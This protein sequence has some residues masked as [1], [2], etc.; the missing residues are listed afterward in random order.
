MHAV[1]V[2]QQ[3]T[4][5]FWLHLKEAYTS[6]ISLKSINMFKC[7]FSLRTFM[8]ETCVM[9]RS[10]LQDVFFCFPLII[11]HKAKIKAISV[12]RNIVN[13]WWF[14]IT[15]LEGD[16]ILLSWRRYITFHLDKHSQF[17]L[18]GL[19]LP[20]LLSLQ[21]LVW[22]AAIIRCSS[23]LMSCDKPSFTAI[24]CAGV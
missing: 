1:T 19:C 8:L 7:I 2:M 17:D 5:E 15:E 6:L 14:Q 16:L 12:L 13:S 24:Y 9:F 18:S 21:N 4:F 23:T 3:V 20:I 22:V 11:K 10:T